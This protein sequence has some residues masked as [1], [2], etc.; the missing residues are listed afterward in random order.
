M[1]CNVHENP[2]FICIAVPYV[3]YITARAWA[4]ATVCIDKST[5]M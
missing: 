2:K 3:E 1:Y 5:E 4:D